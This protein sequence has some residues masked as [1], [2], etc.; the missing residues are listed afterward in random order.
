MSQ[1]RHFKLGAGAYVLGV[2]VLGGIYVQEVSVQGVSVQG[3]ISVRGGGGG[4]TCL[5]FFVL[6][7][8]IDSSPG[9]ADFY[10]LTN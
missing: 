6:S 5:F 10:E 9:N 2:C 8:Y 4:G 1:I 3:G 7:P